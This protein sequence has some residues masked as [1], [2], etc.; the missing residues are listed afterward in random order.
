MPFRPQHPHPYQGHS[1]HS[2]VPSQSKFQELVEKYSPRNHL[3]EYR[4][5]PSNRGSFHGNGGP[6][7]HSPPHPSV[8]QGYQGNSYNP[9]MA[10]ENGRPDKLGFNEFD[11]PSPFNMAAG[12]DDGDRYPFS[13]DDERDSYTYPL[14][15]HQKN[16]PAINSNPRGFEYV[17]RITSSPSSSSSPNDYSSLSFN[18]GLEPV[19][20][21]TNIGRYS[22]LDSHDAFAAYIAGLPLTP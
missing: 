14:P 3:P 4:D 5:Q 11:S 22:G 15:F 6:M 17:N 20:F 12:P 10:Q 1:S 21:S 13:M 2:V 18:S 7:S 8:R 9:G 16:G 19:V